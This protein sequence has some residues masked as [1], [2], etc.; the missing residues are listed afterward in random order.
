MSVPDGAAGGAGAEAAPDG[1]ALEVSV[2]ASG[3]PGREVAAAASALAAA[4]DGRVVGAGPWRCTVAPGTTLAALLRLLG[5]DPARPMLTVVSERR[6]GA[7][8]RAATV[9]R[10][11]DAV[12]LTPAI[13]AG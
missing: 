9:L 8:E 4:G 7:G 12:S 6:V 13:R 10:D 5:V 11:G 3:A 2:R 1:P